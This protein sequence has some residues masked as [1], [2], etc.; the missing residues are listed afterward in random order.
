[1]DNITAAKKKEYRSG[2]PKYTVYQG[3]ITKDTWNFAYLEDAIIEALKWK[4]SH[5]VRTSTN[6]LV[7]SN[8]A[9]Y[10]IYQRSLLL[11]RFVDLDAAILYAN[12]WNH[13]LIKIDESEIWNNWPY[14]QVFQNKTR[15]G[16][17][18]TLKEALKQGFKFEN[19]SVAT[20]HGQKIWDNDRD[21]LFLGWN[22]SYKPESIKS[23]VSQTLGLDI[24][25]PTWFEL[26]DASGNIEDSSDPGLAAWLKQQ[27]IAI[28]PLVH[29]QFNAALTTLFLSNPE[30]QKK[31]IA[32]L[33]Q[34]A[35]ELGVAGLNIDF[36]SISSKDRDAYTAFIA[37][38]TTAAHQRS[39]IISIDLP[40]GSIKWNHLTAYDHVKLAGIVDY[41]ITMTYDQHYSGSLSAGSVAG[42]QWTETGIQEFLSYG[43]PR[44]KLLLGIPFYMREWK[45]D[46][47]G[48]L[49]S[50]R[51]IFMKDITAFM[52]EKKAISTWD[53][54]S[55]Q[56]RVEYMEDGFK[57]VFWLEDEKSV[58]LRLDLA[59]KY[60]LAGVAAWRLGYDQAE[61]WKM[62]IKEK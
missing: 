1:W 49:V 61:L 60:D 32:Q 33:I 10:K 31:F 43:I 35:A 45:I 3:T 14:Y 23:H 26:K 62:M 9:Q 17:H 29:N 28:H 6:N 55:Q 30:A 25:S 7:Y 46:S 8:I 19:A 54:T 36:E 41:I 18:T 53:T 50:N 5:V 52:A 56:Y 24:D 58:K 38:L 59:K 37:A 57:Y 12:K 51:A 48:L 44:D 13:A 21:L 16:E 39:L 27:N 15:I 20:Y 4:N 40:R 34:R 47:N 42:L 2:L 11:D 22:G